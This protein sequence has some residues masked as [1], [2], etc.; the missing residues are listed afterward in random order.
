MK[1]HP[2]GALPAPG[3][4]TAALAV[5]RDPFPAK[6]VPCLPGTKHIPPSRFQRPRD[7]DVLPRPR[8]RKPGSS[9]NPLGV[10]G[11]HRLQEPHDR[12]DVRVP[13]LRQLPIMPPL[14]HARILEQTFDAGPSPCR[15]R[16]FHAS[17]R[18]P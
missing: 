2:A 8:H 11:I 7:L 10:K 9:G 6:S 16:T 13:G 1:A 12:R 18:R 15:A 5:R 14:T 3:D 17:S 4:S